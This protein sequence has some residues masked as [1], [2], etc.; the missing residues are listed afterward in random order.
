MAY[1]YDI[2]VANYSF[3]IPFIRRI[4]NVFYEGLWKGQWVNYVA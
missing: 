4:Y 2:F 1:T 3:Y